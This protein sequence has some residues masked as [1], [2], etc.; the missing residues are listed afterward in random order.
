MHV[1]LNLKN[2]AKSPT[3]IKGN[4]LILGDLELNFLL[5]DLP[6]PLKNI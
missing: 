5:H 6:H 3:Q 1:F 4:L 2:L